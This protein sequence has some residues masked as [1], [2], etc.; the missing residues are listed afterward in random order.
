MWSCFEGLQIETQANEQISTVLLKPNNFF[1]FP[2]GL[3]S[4]K[5]IKRTLILEISTPHFNDRVRLDSDKDNLLLSTEPQDVYEITSHICLSHLERFGFL[6]I[7][8]SSIPSISLTTLS[9]WK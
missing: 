8:S 9:A 5:A 1:I 7:D 6:P 4:E 2:N 3:I